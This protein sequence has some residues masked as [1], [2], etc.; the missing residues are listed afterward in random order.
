MRD[1]WTL[2]WKKK[3]QVVQAVRKEGRKEGAVV[4]VAVE[5][6]IIKKKKK[7]EKT[8]DPRHM[9]GEGFPPRAL[10]KYRVT[11]VVAYLG[12]VDYDYWSFLSSGWA[13]GNLAE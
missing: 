5:K 6:E 7:K 10:D 3:P 1:S 12:W 2:C 4:R 8:D 9:F 13:D 11:L